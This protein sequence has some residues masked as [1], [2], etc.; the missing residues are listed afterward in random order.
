MIPLAFFIVVFIMAVVL[1]YGAAGMATTRELICVTAWHL[2]VTRAAVRPGAQTAFGRQIVRD[3]VQEQLASRVQG[4][5]HVG[6]I[7]GEYV[8]ARHGAMLC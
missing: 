2:L 5:L 4:K 3:L 6:R 1:T 7:G 8:P